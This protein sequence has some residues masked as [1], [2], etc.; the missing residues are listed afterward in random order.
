MADGPW[1]AALASWVRCG[2]LD[3]TFLGSTVISCAW[4]WFFPR[5]GLAKHCRSSFTSVRESCAASMTSVFPVA[6]LMDGPER[7][8]MLFASCALLCSA[9]ISLKSAALCR[10]CWA[11]S[12]SG[13]TRAPRTTASPL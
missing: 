1:L 8:C 4:T 13:L 12:Q 9:Y 11:C 2:A 6:C 7:G 3:C 5:M 10:S